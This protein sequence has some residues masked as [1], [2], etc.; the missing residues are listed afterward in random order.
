MAVSL[1][2][3]VNQTKISVITV[4]YNSAGEIEGFLDSYLANTPRNNWEL[5]IVDNAS[6]DETA[7][8]IRKFL[9]NLNEDRRQ[10]IKFIRSKRNLGYGGGNNLGVRHAKGEYLVFINP[11]TLLL[12]NWLEVLE[13]KQDADSKVGIVGPKILYG[14][15]KTIQAAGGWVEEAG[16]AHHFGYGE[17]DEGQWNEEKEVDYVTGA[18]LAI[19]K[20]IFE[21]CFGFDEN[22]FPGYYEETELCWKAKRLGYKVIYLPD[23]SIIHLESQVTGLYSYNYYYWFHKHRWRFVLKNY[24]VSKILFSA[25]PFELRWLFNNILKKIKIFP[26]PKNNS[27]SKNQSGSSK[28]GNQEGTALLK[29]YFVTIINLPN[30]F[31][32][33]YFK[34]YA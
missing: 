7:D 12:P 4:A 2:I 14:D 16:F 18:C 24:P 11:D 23:S 9:E 6:Q 1:F 30:I 26:S 5:I 20:S 10:Q 21:K 32:H 29:A 3:M 13:K 17:K 8:K 15:R 22:Y 19:R 25:I 31:Y 33:R 27:G 34:Y 28:N